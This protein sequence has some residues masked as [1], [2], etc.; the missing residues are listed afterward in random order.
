MIEKQ[1]SEII[2]QHYSEV[3][4]K[5]GQSSQFNQRNRTFTQYTVSARPSSLK[6]F[7]S[8]FT[9]VSEA[10][11]DYELTIENIIVKGNRVMARY[12]ICGTHKGDFMG[13][14]PSNERIT[15]TGI[16]I[17]R[18]DNGKVVEHW[19]AAHQISALPHLNIDS[20]VSAGGVSRS[21]L[22]TTRSENKQFSRSI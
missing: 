20:M 18:L 10:F 5:R 9:Q 15:V 21:R 8:F 17:F 4:T 19:D 2:R 1:N 16:D 13:M 7:N 6:A 14:P 12:T 11:P 3:S 22:T